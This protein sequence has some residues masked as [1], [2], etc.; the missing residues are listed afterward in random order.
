MG[1]ELICEPLY[2]WEDR[3]R[4]KVLIRDAEKRLGADLSG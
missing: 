1:F 3:E 2:L 4:Q